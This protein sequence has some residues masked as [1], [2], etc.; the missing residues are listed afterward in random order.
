MFYIESEVIRNNNQFLLENIEPS[1]FIDLLH[2][3]NCITDEERYHLNNQPNNFY[4]NDA[5]LH[6]MRTIAFKQDIIRRTVLECMRQSEKN[7]VVASLLSKGGGNRYKQNQ[8]SVSICL[9]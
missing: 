4:K 2:E 3:K 9:T 5:L 1:R 7:F 8:L 6:W